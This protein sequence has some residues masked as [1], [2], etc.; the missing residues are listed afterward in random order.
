MINY[1]KGSE[2]TLIDFGLSGRY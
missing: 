1:S 2:V